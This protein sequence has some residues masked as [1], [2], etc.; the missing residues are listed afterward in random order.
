MFEAV[1][2]AP[3]ITDLLAMLGSG[4]TVVGGVIGWLVRT[5]NWR[6]AFENLALGATAGGVCGCLVAFLYYIGTKVAGG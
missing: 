5:P 4:G 1:A 3:A 6:Q 2:R